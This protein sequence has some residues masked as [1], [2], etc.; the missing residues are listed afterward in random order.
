MRMAQATAFMHGRDFV[1]PEDVAE[2][3]VPV[4]SHRIALH[5]E[6]RS[7]GVTADA[8]LY[9]ILKNTDVPYKK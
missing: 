9:D 3:F 4:T 1:I 2:V 8:V 7:T 6:A 5:R